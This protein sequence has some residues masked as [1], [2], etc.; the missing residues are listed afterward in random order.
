[1]WTWLVVFRIFAKLTSQCWASVSGVVDMQSASGCLFSGSVGG[2]A[3]AA[4]GGPSARIFPS[5]AVS[6]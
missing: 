4:Q 6:I 2:V 3:G 1:M 5:G